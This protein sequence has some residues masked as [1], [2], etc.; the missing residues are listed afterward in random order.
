MNAARSF[1]IRDE[2]LQESDNL[3]D[4]DMLARKSS[5]ISKSFYAIGLRPRTTN[6]SQD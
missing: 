1:F 3:P 5:K 4:P 2:S 6:P